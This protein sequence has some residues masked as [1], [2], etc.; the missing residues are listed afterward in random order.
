MPV[1]PS[2]RSALQLLNLLLG[3][4]RER[5]IRVLLHHQRERLARVLGLAGQLIGAA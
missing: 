5:R 1:S 2:C 3:L 4:I